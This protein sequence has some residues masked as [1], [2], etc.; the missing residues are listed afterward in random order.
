MGE[1]ELLGASVAFAYPCPSV[2]RYGRPWQPAEFPGAAP[3]KN[4]EEVVR[5]CDPSRAPP[6]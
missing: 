3:V 5:P 2:L 1:N 6:V 4:E